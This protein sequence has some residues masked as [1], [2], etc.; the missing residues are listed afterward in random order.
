M[1][2]E[3]S[4]AELC[5]G[6]D[7]SR[8]ITA[9]GLIRTLLDR[10]FARAVPRPDVQV[11]PAAVSDLFAPQINFVEH[12]M[13]A[14][15]R[16]PQE[17]FARFRSSRILV[18][19]PPG[20]VAAAAVRGLL[21]NGLAETTLDDAAWGSEFD[22]ET[23]R[24][25]EAG[26]P[27]HVVVLPSTP[28]DLTP[29]DVVVA[30][31]DGS[32]G[33]ALL[34]LTERLHGALR[35]PRL[36]PVVADRDHVV[37]GP[38]SGPAEQPCWVCARLRL[39]ANSDPR[40]MADFWRAMAIGPTGGEAP[41]A[42]DTPGGS[43]VAQSMAGNAVAFEVFRLRTG[44]LRPDDERHAVIQDLTTLESGRE[45]V[46]PHPG[47]PMRHQRVEPDDAVRP[48]ADDS[49]AYGRAAVLVSPEFGLLSGWTDDSIRQIPLKTGR[50]RL[51][52]AGSPA[53]EAREIAAFDADTV[54]V[55]RTRA[56]QAAVVCYLGRLG[57]S[58]LPDQAGPA[59]PLDG[60]V[61]P[62]ER[63]ALFSG[64]PV[65]EEDPATRARL[66]A[67]SLHDGSH[68]QV[69]AAAVHPLSPANSR[70]LFEPSPAGAA[71]G[72]TVA[73]VQERGLCSALA[74]RGLV[75]AIR[76]EEPALPLTEEWLAGDDETAFALGSLRHIGRTA[77]LYALPGAAPAFAVLAVVEG[78]DGGAVDWAT[79][80]ALSVRAAV[81]EAV[82]DAVGLAVGRHY[83]GAPL[84][85]GD[86]LVADFDPR[87]LAE[88]DAK[89]EWSFDQPGMPMPEALGRLDADGTRV[90]FADTTPIDLSAV[91]AMV[92]G[93]I[94]LAEK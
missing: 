21:R 44:Q 60:D 79:G 15:Q 84:D 32:R 45:R 25:A 6:L 16:T 46:L 57:P 17:L 33:G 2:G 62:A 40:L 31:A 38:V 19:G 69:P 43:T 75:R 36:V 64:L 77:R 73:D 51:G 87:T 22:T 93:T 52:P 91:R 55:A 1:T 35:G 94:L 85:P 67:V 8:R 82:R 72:W 50:V 3:S 68:W 41:N 54:L 47:C 63:L 70:L 80:S 18:S 61:V 56:V 92:T 90:L 7:D 39:S 4:I 34:E 65:A 28:E 12:F 89:A 81:R 26:A 30:V 9:V 10:G 59:A 78:A 42:G 53:D 37:L 14:D 71:A 29:Y 11:L 76:G 13:H 20:S 5:D 48:P 74:Q 86:P 27:A 58:G 83:E 49:D 23:A 88:G 24:L 66:S